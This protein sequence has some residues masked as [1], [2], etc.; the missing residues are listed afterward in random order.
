MRLVLITVVA[1]LVD[2]P[3]LEPSLTMLSLELS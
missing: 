3:T 1:G 2:S